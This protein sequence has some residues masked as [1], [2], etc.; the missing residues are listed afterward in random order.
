MR[1][2]RA[3]TEPGPNGAVG[4]VRLE[5]LRE[6]IQECEA[7]IAIERALLARAVPAPLA[8]E[9]TAL[10]VERMAARYKDG[11]F[12]ASHGARISSPQARVWG[13][14]PNWQDLTARLF[15]L[16]GRV[17]AAQRAARQ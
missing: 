8:E 11:K 10:L 5:M 6:G 16:A 12:T 7:R 15:D 3:I 2:R 1:A 9:C 4:T 13:M 17:E 14:A